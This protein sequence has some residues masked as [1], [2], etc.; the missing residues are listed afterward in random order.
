MSADSGRST[1]ACCTWE[2]CTRA[3][4]HRG[5]VAFARAVESE[6]RCDLHRDEVA[7]PARPL[8]GIDLMV[9]GS[10]SV[11]AQT[12]RD[13]AHDIG[14]PSDKVGAALARLVAQGVAKETRT[15]AGRGY[16]LATRPERP[17]PLPLPV[18]VRR[19]PP[20]PPRP[21]ASQEPDLS[22]YTAIARRVRQRAIDCIELHGGEVSRRVLRDAMKVSGSH[23]RGVLDA[24]LV[25]TIELAPNQD[26]PTTDRTMF[27]LQR[28]VRADVETPAAPGAEPSPVEP[29]AP[30]EVEEQPA[31]PAEI[32]ERPPLPMSGAE[33]HWSSYG[34]SEEQAWPD[35]PEATGTR[36]W[37]TWL[38]LAAPLAGE[39]PVIEAWHRERAL[40]LARRIQMDH[41]GIRVIVPHTAVRPIYDDCAAVDGGTT[42][43]HGLAH[44]LELL[45]LVKLS[46]GE[47]RVL[48]RDDGTLS[49]GCLAEVAAWESMGGQPPRQIGWATFDWPE[50]LRVQAEALREPPAPS[51]DVP[52]TLS[53]CWAEIRRLKHHHDDLFQVF[54]E[55]VDQLI[56]IRLLLDEAGIPRNVEG[57]DGSTTELTAVERVRL[58]VARQQI[59]DTAVGAARD[60]VDIARG[61][62]A[63]T[64]A[65]LSEALRRTASSLRDAGLLDPHGAV[66]TTIDGLVEMVGKAAANVAFARG[67][68]RV[69]MQHLVDGSVDDHDMPK[70]LFEAAAYVERTAAAARKQW[71]DALRDARDAEERAL[72]RPQHPTPPDSVPLDIEAAGALGCV[73]SAELKRINA[74]RQRWLIA[75]HLADTVVA[76]QVTP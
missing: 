38:Y 5:L 36:T 55:Q 32:I 20:P 19:P 75:L 10:L 34:A 30:I 68:L 67:H 63:K 13:I 46:G 56:A 74:E 33:L 37:P 18:P 42:R 73:A 47:M 24:L 59:V 27:R 48:Q 49:P 35:W 26:L 45:R 15:S 41:P 51:I 66:A 72:N 2:G 9:L 54:S 28:N 4:T 64:D 11:A 44:S 50:E 8:E 25:D 71:H 7:R 31:E 3:A 52:S 65:K 58:L 60:F 76:G 17:V 23:V 62:A 22:D 70:L 14:I 1:V 16:A 21:Q 6:P 12:A 61:S 53:L 69:A 29:P 43:A 40:L 39:T 57:E